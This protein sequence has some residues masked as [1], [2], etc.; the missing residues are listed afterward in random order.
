MII[1]NL[2]INKIKQKYVDKPKPYERSRKK[3]DIP[4]YLYDTLNLPSLP[5]LDFHTLVSKIIPQESIFLII[6]TIN[7]IYKSII[8]E[9][10]MNNLIYR[11]K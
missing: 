7:N 6:K 8:Y 3:L 11:R 2:Y 4:S 10:I 9:K 1:C 5:Q